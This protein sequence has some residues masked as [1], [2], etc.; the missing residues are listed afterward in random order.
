MAAATPE[1]LWLERL[2]IT[3]V[4]PGR[5]TLMR[6]CSTQAWNSTPLIAPSTQSGATK[7][8][9]RIA[10]RK[11]VVS[12]A[13]IR[14][15]FDQT[16]SAGTATIGSRHVGLGP[17]FIDEHDSIWIEAQLGSRPLPACFDNVFPLLL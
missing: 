3:T 11:V 6:C 15:P 12:R 7:P 13:S 1:P 16:L 17:R 10:P 2:S 8:V 9:E 14:H 5:S 4:S